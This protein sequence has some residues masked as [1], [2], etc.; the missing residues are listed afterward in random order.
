MTKEEKV[1]VDIPASLLRKV[2]ERMKGTDFKS[3][4]EY[5]TYVLEEIVKDDDDDEQPYSQED[6][7]VV[8]ARL[9]SLGYLD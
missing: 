1:Q 9:R 4:S 2:Q 7:E 5:V 6:E 3:V 8:K